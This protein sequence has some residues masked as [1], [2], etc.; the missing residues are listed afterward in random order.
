MVY[1]VLGITKGKNRRI[2]WNSGC[3]TMSRQTPENRNTEEVN[4]RMTSDP[5]GLVMED[6]PDLMLTPKKLG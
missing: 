3:E 6:E 2:D 1:A 4:D 5:D